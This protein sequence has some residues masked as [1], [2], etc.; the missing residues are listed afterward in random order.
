MNHWT[1]SGCVVVVLIWS[2]I[3]LLLAVLYQGYNNISRLN[4]QLILVVC[5]PAFGLQCK[6]NCITFGKSFALS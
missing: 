3:E 6:C 1:D 5:F 2:A 4:L